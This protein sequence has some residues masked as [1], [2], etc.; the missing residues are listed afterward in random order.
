MP[1]SSE[2][3]I[4]VVQSCKLGK[5]PNRFMG[6]SGYAK[7]PLMRALLMRRLRDSNP[8]YLAVR[9]FS[10]PVQSTNSA[11]PPCGCKFT[12]FI[13]KCA[14]FGIQINRALNL[15]GLE[16]PLLNDNKYYVKYHR[17]Q[18]R[19]RVVPFTA[20]ACWK[21]Y[22]SNPLILSINSSWPVRA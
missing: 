4:P 3:H 6:I 21:D 13:S 15:S 20:I 9:R 8:R 17:E 22:L 18:K 16:P 5:S 1:P 2:S 11:K 19:D 12:S 10:R 14:V 7:R